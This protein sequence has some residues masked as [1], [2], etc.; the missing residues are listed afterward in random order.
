MSGINSIGNNSPVQKIISQ[1][2]QKQVPATPAKQMPAATKVELS[3]M[4]PMLKAL[5][6]NDIRADKVAMIKQQIEAGTYEDAAKLDSA[7]DKLIDD[8]SR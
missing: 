6:T 3:G 1:P 4:G 5:Q 2:I 8:L 7:I